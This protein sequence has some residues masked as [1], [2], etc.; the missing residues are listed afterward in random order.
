[1]ASVQSGFVR[2]RLVLISIR[3]WVTVS[4]RRVI[5]FRC[6]SMS[7]TFIK[8]SF[9]VTTETPFRMRISTIHRDSVSFER[10]IPFERLKNRRISSD[11]TNYWSNSSRKKR[12]NEHELAIRAKRNDNISFC[13]FAIFNISM[14]TR[15][16]LSL[17]RN[18]HDLLLL[19]LFPMTY[20]DGKVWTD[21]STWL[22]KLKRKRYDW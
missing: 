16:F 4:A 11:D 9:I 5:I 18:I 10:V 6:E 13:V 17:T 2:A 20:S 12:F 1:M 22:T 7:S 14:P 8:M 15:R 19:F 3:N 21:I